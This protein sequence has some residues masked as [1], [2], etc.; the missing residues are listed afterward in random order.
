MSK[1]IDVR[2]L[3]VSME[4]LKVASIAFHLIDWGVINHSRRLTARSEKRLEVSEFLREKTLVESKLD[5]R[6]ILAYSDSCGRTA[7]S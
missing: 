3:H 6:S 4:L 7:L 1:G 2:V 5:E